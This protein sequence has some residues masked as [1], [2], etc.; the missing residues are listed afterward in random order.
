MN[1]E[2]HIA[3]MGT[4]LDD[5]QPVMNSLRNDLAQFLGSFPMHDDDRGP[6]NTVLVDLLP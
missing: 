4:F 6:D 2:L 5:D 3:D 1:D